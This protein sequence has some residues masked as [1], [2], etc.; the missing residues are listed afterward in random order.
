MNKRQ[1][2]WTAVLV[3]AAAAVAALVK[4]C[5]MP[6]PDWMAGELVTRYAPS[7]G[8]SATFLRGKQIDD[9]LRVD[10]TVLQATD[11]AG[12][13][14]LLNDFNV[15]GITENQQK[16]LG[17]GKDI[18]CFKLFRKDNTPAPIDKEAVNNVV[19]ISYLK[20]AVCVYHT[21]THEQVDR[22]L[23][24]QIKYSISQYKQHSPK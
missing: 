1:L 19:A 11:S 16:A 3:L 21:E 4:S 18:I 17:Q 7:D 9:S 10:V 6:L 12:W 13:A 8:V 5:P 24:Y 2:I 15:S 14:R 20:H 23:E 22:I